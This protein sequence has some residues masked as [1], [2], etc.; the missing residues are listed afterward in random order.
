MYEKL[1]EKEFSDL[2]NI[3]IIIGIPTRNEGDNIAFVT[4]QIDEGLMKTFPGKKALIVVCDGNSTDDTKKVFLDMETLASKRYISTPPNV[5]GKGNG[6]RQLFEVVKFI[7]PKAIMVAD[8]DLTSIT[9]EWV[10]KMLM[11][12]MNEYDYVTP[13]YNRNRFDGSITNNICFPIIY[14][15]LGYDIRQ[16]IAGDFAFSPRLAEYWLEQKWIDS[17]GFYGIDIFMTTHAIFGNFRICQVSLGEKAHKPSAPKLDN[18]FSEVVGTLFD[19]V[20]SNEA[21]WVKKSFITDV[22]VMGMSTLDEP[23]LDI[24]KNKIYETARSKYNKYDLR[25][26]LEK[27]TFDKINDMFFKRDLNVTSELW[28]KV[29]YDSL[30][31]YHKNKTKDKREKII[32]ALKAVYFARMFTFMNKFEHSSREEVEESFNE[33][34]ENFRKFKPYFVEKING[35]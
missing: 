21:K 20:V 1:I 28:A 29:V 10:R 26:F 13:Y 9:P 22:K 31:A 8:A 11:P 23:K 5:Y 2:E 34:A 24:D 14:G 7:K 19:N 33:Q 3:E 30:H 32:E 35:Q 6:F 16:P 25:E 18:M 15:L 17:T 27:E 12:I 4:K